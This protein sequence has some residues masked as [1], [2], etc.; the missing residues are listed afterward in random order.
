M[1]TNNNNPN[2][3]GKPYVR[4]EDMQMEEWS[5]NSD[6]A[7]RFIN[8]FS[9]DGTC[10]ESLNNGFENGVSSSN[11]E[12]LQPPLALNG[13]TGSSF[14]SPVQHISEQLTYAS[15]TPALMHAPKG[16]AA[17]PHYEF[18]GQPTAVQ[19]HD[20]IVYKR[21]KGLYFSITTLPAPFMGWAPI[22]AQK[23]PREQHLLA[24][25]METRSCHCS[26]SRIHLLN[27]GHTVAVPRDAEQ[28]A[29]NCVGMQT[30]LGN[31]MVAKMFTLVQRSHATV[32][33]FVQELEAQ[34]TQEKLEM[35]RAMKEGYKQMVH[36]QSRVNLLDGDFNCKICGNGGMREAVPAYHFLP[37]Y[38]IIVVRDDKDAAIVRELERGVRPESKKIKA[39]RH[40]DRILEIVNQV[41][42]AHS[43]NGGGRGSYG[44]GLG[45]TYRGSGGANTSQSFS[46]CPAYGH[47]CRTGG[48]RQRPFNNF[49]GHRHDHTSSFRGRSIKHRGGFTQGRCALP[50]YARPTNAL[51]S[52]SS[53]PCGRGNFIF[54]S[55]RRRGYFNNGMRGRGYGV[56][57][58]RVGRQTA[59]ARARAEEKA[60][61]LQQIQGEHLLSLLQDPRMRRGDRDHGNGI[62][63]NSEAMEQ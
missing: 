11:S 23:A 57:H 21:S 26:K 3:Q 58:G 56:A 19:M 8:A 55:G 50:H 35:A 45:D 63:N 40:L 60:G 1:S 28:C 42:V 15:I 10:T 38:V 41:S 12:I 18:N 13:S 9:S 25:Q 62:G 7:T 2:T 31:E 49:S 44:P 37:M 5:H 4:N 17:L 47:G 30:V 33:R 46:L 48:F 27:C 22:S 24:P 52:G 16:P 34:G 43:T 53:A 51:G 20:H 14:L 39:A 61:M 6:P 29:A 59:I 54:S 36:Q 32:S